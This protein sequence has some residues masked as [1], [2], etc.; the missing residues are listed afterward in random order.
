MKYLRCTQKLLKEIGI[1]VSSENEVFDIQTG[2]GDWYVNLIRI[3]RRKNLLFTNE[4]TLF[5][6]LVPKVLKKDIL[7]IKNKFIAN[8]VYNLQYEGFE[9]SL[10]T[11]IE[12]E[13]S[14][15]MFGK[16][17]SKSVLGS[18]NDI[19]THVRFILSNPELLKE[20]ELGDI[21]RELNRIPH[22]PLGYKFPIEVLKEKFE[23]L[24]LN[25]RLH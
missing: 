22:G 19:A 8:L 14:K 10:I 25:S 4:N 18:M 16:T 13:Y 5:S 12:E 1:A 2:L 23:K 20:P 9:G 6:F 21:N 3:D 24:Y 15:I 7:D 17:K 11:S